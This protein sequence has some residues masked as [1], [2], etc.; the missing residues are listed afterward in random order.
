MNGA[1]ND[2]RRRGRAKGTPAPHSS[3]AG[4][5]YEIRVALG[6]TRELVADEIGMTAAG[7]REVENRGGVPA[8]GRRRLAGRLARRALDV[9]VAR[10]EDARATD[11]R[12]AWGRD[13]DIPA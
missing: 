13:L 2:A 9:L 8:G 4:T 3:G 5:L 11:Y 12:T 6:W 10:G 7:V 1:K